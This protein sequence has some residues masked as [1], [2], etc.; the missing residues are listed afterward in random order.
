MD[1]NI[2]ELLK[3]AIIVRNIRE[4][5]IKFYQKLESAIRGHNLN[6]KWKH[7][8]WKYQR[9]YPSFKTAHDSCENMTIIMRGRYNN[10]IETLNKILEQIIKL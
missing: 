7:I 8:S 9:K 5:Q 1:N 6:D 3:I 2:Q 10:S 4:N